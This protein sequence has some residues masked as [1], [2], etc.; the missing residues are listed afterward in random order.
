MGLE[1][2]FGQLRLCNEKVIAVQISYS[3]FY[4]EAIAFLKRV[5]KACKGK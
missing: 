3:R 2:I 5:K 4:F 1:F